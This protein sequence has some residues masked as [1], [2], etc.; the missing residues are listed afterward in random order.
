MLSTCRSA[1]VLLHT[2][3]PYVL[4]SPAQT[5]TQVRQT[6]ELSEAAG[7]TIRWTELS[8]VP[9]KLRKQM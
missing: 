2:S 1:S 8:V 3:D 4:T 7:V 5:S 9:A 6:V